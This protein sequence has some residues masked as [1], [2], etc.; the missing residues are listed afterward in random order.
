MVGHRTWTNIPQTH[1]ETSKPSML[2]VIVCSSGLH[3]RIQNCNVVEDGLES[4]HRA[5]CIDVVTTS[6][7]FKENS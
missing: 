6:I 3:K 2:D 5:V 1:D 4:D 7:K